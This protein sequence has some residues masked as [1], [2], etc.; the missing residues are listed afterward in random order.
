M[1]IARARSIAVWWFAG[2]LCV[3]AAALPLMPAFTSNVAAAVFLTLYLQ[4]TRLV[5]SIFLFRSSRRSNQLDS[6]NASPRARSEAVLS[7]RPTSSEPGGISGGVPVQ[8]VWVLN[9]V[10]TLTADTTD[11]MLHKA[12]GRWE[13]HQQAHARSG[14]GW[15]AIAAQSVATFLVM[16]VFMS[17][18]RVTG[19]REIVLWVLALIAAL[20]LVDSI[21]RAMF[22]AA[23]RTES[24][25]V[26]PVMTSPLAAWRDIAVNPPVCRWS[27]G[28][29]RAG[30][31][32]RSD[33][34]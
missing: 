1:T 21:L 34:A 16:W 27:S 10:V 32:E 28:V 7:G 20:S 15:F 29:I 25:A 2:S 14:H 26:A 8:T 5:G 18:G 6:I 24:I 23:L 3:L 17:M 9:R 19:I 12:V 31:L 22:D 30:A 13:S 33:H 11:E 4:A